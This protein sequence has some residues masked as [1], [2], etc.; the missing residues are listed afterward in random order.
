MWFGKQKCP[1]EENAKFRVVGHSHVKTRQVS[2]FEK[3]L[4]KGIQPSSEQTG[5][6]NSGS[7]FRAPR[8]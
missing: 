2:K 7:A 4:V 5:S 1:F 8:C 6:K 3:Q